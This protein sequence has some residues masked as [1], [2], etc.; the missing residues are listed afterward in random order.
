MGF[1]FVKRLSLTAMLDGDFG[2]EHNGCYACILC[3]MVF[4]VVGAAHQ[5]RM[6]SLL[7]KIRVEEEVK[8][9]DFGP[10]TGAGMGAT[11][12]SWQYHGPGVYTYR[13]VAT[14]LRL[15]G[16]IPAIR[17]QKQMWPRA[18]NTSTFT[19]R[20][21]P[22]ANAF[23]TQAKH[24]DESDSDDEEDTDHLQDRRD[25]C[26]DLFGTLTTTMV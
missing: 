2:C 11:T 26:F 7:T 4:G 16:R 18:C 22:Q 8:L 17:Y 19:R 3:I 23:Q 9:W 5:F 14:S 10:C 13:V 6:V 21:H 15:H 12:M 1:E 20:C 24:H 25:S